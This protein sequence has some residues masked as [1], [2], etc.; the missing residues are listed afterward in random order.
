[1]TCLQPKPYSTELIKCQVSKLIDGKLHENLIVTVSADW[2]T[3][4]TCCSTKNTLTL[5][6]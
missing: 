5:Y 4:Y 3:N 6:E 2:G 1:M